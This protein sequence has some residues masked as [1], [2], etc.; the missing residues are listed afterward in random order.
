MSG[1]EEGFGDG[2]GGIEGLFGME[3]EGE[4]LVEEVVLLVE[5]VE[6]EGVVAGGGVGEFVL[7]DGDAGAHE[8]GEGGEEEKD[9]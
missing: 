7:V 9:F 6:G 8:G 1:E 2:R 4:G 5:F 3:G